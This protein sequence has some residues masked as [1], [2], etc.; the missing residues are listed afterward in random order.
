MSRP[1][2]PA[3]TLLG[4]IDRRRTGLLAALSI[5]SALTEGIGL[6]LLVPM[7]DTLGQRAG[8]PGFLGDAFAW[9]GLPRSLPVLLGLFVA[10]V[11]ARGVLN[12]WRKLTAQDVEVE[13]VDGLRRRAWRALL[14]CDWRTLAGMRQSDNASLLISSL[15]RVS[16][17]AHHFIGASVSLVTLG[18]IALAALAISPFTSLV[19][20]VGGGL[21]LT[22][23]GR[24]RRRA[25]MLGEALGRSYARVYAEIGEG[26]AALR[27]IKSFGIERAFERRLS[28]EIGSLRG[29]E[30]A[31]LRD[32]GLAQLLLQACGA[33]VLAAVVWGAIEL[34]HAPV[35]AVLPMV[36]LF[37]RAL[38]LIGAVQ[39]AWQG[40][41]HARPALDETLA[42]LGVAEAA[43]EPEPPPGTPVPEGRESIRVES[44]GVAY[45]G[46]TRPALAD[47][48]V[49]LTPGTV[50]AVIGPSGSGKS[51]LADVFGG[52]IPPDAGALLIDG[53]PLDSA[54]RRA[55][56]RQ[57]AYVQQEAVLFTGSVRD[58]LRL[59]A[60]DAGEEQLL[61]ALR[62]ASADFVERLP[63]GLDTAVG[64]GGR[65]LSGG[66]RQ[67]IALARALLR[68]PRLL[69]LDE[70]A[71]ALDSE[72]EMAIARA[73][74]AM[75][76][77]MAIFVIG[78]RGALADIADRTV[79]LEAG[80]LR[81]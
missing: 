21:A 13:L 19:A 33:I 28:D 81:P 12:F 14:H 60:P 52:L 3:Q 53:T 42:L 70:A 26:L 34:W 67:R 15:D 23:Y 39:E 11:L 55:W 61:D 45:P 18:G 57:V 36:A 27:V 44:L 78:H 41:A 4:L 72:N 80:R 59:S 32:A 71:S 58:N 65:E 22:A 31:Y 24:M 48:D 8:S 40:W 30:R 62:R 17:A 37:A 75:K 25:A 7:L 43:H 9:L 51:T 16:E 56:R 54:M 50:T 74:A 46:R 49:E 66:E 2:R 35:I 63:E 64:E 5:A 77:D 79:R 38:P 68:R 6:V 76:A 10:L 73:V 29:A 47:I 20:V 69:I 1:H